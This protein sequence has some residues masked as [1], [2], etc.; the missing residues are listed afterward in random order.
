MYFDEFVFLLFP[1]L[2][3]IGWESLSMVNNLPWLFSFEHVHNWTVRVVSHAYI[4][5]HACVHVLAIS[6]S[7]AESR[8]RLQSK[9]HINIIGWCLFSKLRTVHHCIWINNRSSNFI[10]LYSVDKISGIISVGFILTSININILFLL[11]LLYFGCNIV[12]SQS[13]KKCK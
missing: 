5:S 2:T 3:V 12:L 4:T 6:S 10:L 9:L 7:A 13:H 11:I 1:S 8:N